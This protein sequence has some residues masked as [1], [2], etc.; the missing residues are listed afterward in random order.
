MRRLSSKVIREMLRLKAMGF[1]NTQ[2]SASVGKSRPKVIEYL[3]KAAELG[4]DWEKAKGMADAD[5]LLLFHPAAGVPRYKKP[6]PDFAAVK[7]ELSKHKSLN[8]RYLWTEYKENDPDG[9]EYSQFCARYHDWARK[10]NVTMA[11]DRK[12]GEEMQVDWAG[13]KLEILCD[14]DTGELFKVHFFVATLGFSGHPYCEAFRDEKIASWIAGHIHALEYYGGVP[15]ILVPDNCKTATTRPNH[16]DPEVNRTYQELGEHYDVAIVPARVAT[17][18]DKPIVEGGVGFLETWLLGRLRNQIFFTLEDLNA[19]IA[20]LLWDLVNQPF[21]KRPGSRYSNFVEVDRPALRPLPAARF[22]QPDWKE[23]TVPDNYHVPYDGHYYSV[24]YVH[25]RKRIWLR[26]TATLVEIFLEG[27]RLCSHK[28]S[29]SKRAT[30]RY[31]TDDAHMPESHRRYREFKAWDGARY[32]GW[33]ERI[34]EHTGLVVDTML[35][36]K[37]HEEQAFRACMA[38]LQLSST[39]DETRLESACARACQMQSLSYTTVRNI[40]KNGQDRIPDLCY[41]TDSV[42]VAHHENER[43]AAYYC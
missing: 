2:I 31:V 30:E 16:Y 14:R 11:I 35:R 28:R 15:R 41:T 21:Q 38:L 25:H 7:A 20:F 18:K 24:P 10:A 12:A 29:H 4:V 13:D 17:P 26:A 23:C 32:R 33:A 19:H 36:A 43:G 42:C 40:L 39:Y 1:N 9:L 22:E 5:L 37:K 34:G 8:L 3:K 6:E 27:A